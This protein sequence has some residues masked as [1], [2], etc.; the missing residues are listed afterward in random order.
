MRRLR[1]VLLATTIGALLAVPAAQ[2]SGPAVRG[3]LPADARAHGH[4]LAE[5]GTAWSLWAWGTAAE[6]NPLLAVR[7]EQSSVDP[8]IWFLPV[9]LGGEWTNTC[10][11][12]P[13]S[14]LVML[15]GGF[16]CSNLEPEPWYGADLAD[17]QDCT[18]DGFATLTYVEVTIDGRTVTN[19]DDYI[20]T[21]DLLTLPENNLLSA[22]SGLSLSKGFFLVIRPLSPRH[23]HAALLRRVLGRLPGRDHLHG[24]RRVEYATTFVPRSTSAGARDSFGYRVITNTVANR[25]DD[26]PD[27]DDCGQVITRSRCGSPEG[28]RLAVS[29]GDTPKP[30][31]ADHEPD[32]S[33]SP[34][35]GHP[36]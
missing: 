10:E 18:N 21:T 31:H 19:I 14:F 5:L 8:R 9:S 26:R 3:I 23:A 32:Q 7:C 29:S 6:D 27:R 34:R 13:G 15:P 1:A 28:P 35:A 2:A 25:H 16:E 33:R 30:D 36:K 20:L 12:P 4:T 22:D 11:V 17:L 24:R